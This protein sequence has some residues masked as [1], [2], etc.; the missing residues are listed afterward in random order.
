[1]FCLMRDFLKP[2]NKLS[3]LAV[4][5]E[6][7]QKIAY[8]FLLIKK[9]FYLRKINDNNNSLKLTSHQIAT[10]NVFLLIFHVKLFFT[11]KSTMKSVTN[12]VD[13]A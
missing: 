4:R 9:C 11:A 1:M 10:F 2:F 7:E 12:F 5:T 6:K 13:V 8:N 3:R